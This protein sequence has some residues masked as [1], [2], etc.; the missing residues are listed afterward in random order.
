MLG[1]RKDW[2]TKP[3]QDPHHQ[4]LPCRRSQLW[5]GG[6][7]DLRRQRLVFAASVGKVT[8]TGEWSRSRPSVS[9]TRHPLAQIHLRGSVG[10]GRIAVLRCGRNNG[11]VA[12]EISFTQLAAEVVVAVLRR[13]HLATVRQGRL[14]SSTTSQ[15]TQ[16][17]T[18]TR[19]AVTAAAIAALGLSACS[20]G[21]SA[22]PADGQPATPQVSTPAQS[23]A[24]ADSSAQATDPNVVVSVGAD[25]IQAPGVSVGA[26]GNIQAPGVSVGPDGIEVSVPGDSS[27]SQSATQSTPNCGGASTV[28]A[29]NAYVT[30]KGHCETI[31]ITASNSSVYYESAGQVIIE[32]T[33]NYV[34]GG[35]TTSVNISS[36]GNSFYVEGELGSATVS[37]NDN[38]LSAT[39]IA[40]SIDNTGSDN[41][42]HNG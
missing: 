29:D 42:I 22:A 24:A 37:G 40:G 3:S 17:I 36:D 34:S 9:S 1:N 25:G 13:I 6:L 14:K 12:A 28:S 41:S 35:A 19:F 39:V 21:V 23:P 10:C 30:L 4:H 26:D 31:H 33:N 2:L 5:L 7:L 16:M 11:A 38:Y 27:S 20:A 8:A 32:G 15:E 18:F